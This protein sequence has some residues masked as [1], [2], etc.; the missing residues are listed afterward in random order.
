MPGSGGRV[1][2]LFSPVSTDTWKRLARIGEVNSLIMSDRLSTVQAIIL[3]LLSC[4]GGPI[5]AIFLS[6]PPTGD[7]RN[8]PVSRTNAM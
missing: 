1:S 4:G 8:T 3:I 2:R 5:S 6:P 7:M